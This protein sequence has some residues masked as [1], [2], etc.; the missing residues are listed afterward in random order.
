VP[1]VIVLDLMMPVMDGFT[2][3]EYVQNDP[4]WNL[5]PVIILTAMI[6]SPEE[7]ARLEKSTVAVLIKGREATERVVES[8]LQMARHRRR[9]M[10]EVIT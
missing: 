6:L 4:V 9:V 7:V 5:I 3:L 10:E 1:S 2:F 8:I